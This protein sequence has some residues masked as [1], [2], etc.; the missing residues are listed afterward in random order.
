MS[1]ESPGDLEGMKQAG[2]VVALILAE[3]GAAVRPGM[4]TAELDAIGGAAMRRHDARSAPQMVYGFPGFTCI[5]VNEQI[6]HG[7]PGDRRL[8]AGDAVKIDVTVDR[9]GFIAD[10]ATTVLIGSTSGTARRLKQSALAA[11]TA[12][13]DAARAGERVGAIG[14][15]VERQ[16]RRDGFS[17]IRELCGH[18]VGRQIHEEPEVVNYDNPLAT[19]RLTDGL[20]IAIEPML[21][22]RPARAVQQPDGW[23]MATSNGCLAVHEEH[24][25]MIRNGEPLVLTAM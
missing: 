20:V 16:V 8:R 4:T 24:T 14:R 17:V 18:G 15:A 5:S 22:A 10:A 2:R 23:T 7:V 9:G 1:I 19:T 3:M 11:L 12:A 6:V 21:A 25:V 13:L